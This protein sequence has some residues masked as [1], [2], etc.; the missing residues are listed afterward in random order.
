MVTKNS[1]EVEAII[2]VPLEVQTNEPIKKFEH[3]DV[4]IFKAKSGKSVTIP[5]RKSDFPD[6]ED[7]LILNVSLKGLREFLDNDQYRRFGLN[8]I[9]GI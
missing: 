9:R 3:V 6:G 7:E 2:E 5:V 4:F 1:G 8:R